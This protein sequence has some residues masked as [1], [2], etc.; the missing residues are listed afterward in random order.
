MLRAFSAIAAIIVSTSVRFAIAGKYLTTGQDA[1]KSIVT[2]DV[3]LQRIPAGHGAENQPAN[4]AEDEIQ[5]G[6]EAIEGGDEDGTING[7]LE[8]SGTRRG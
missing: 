1:Q 3:L 8:I 6:I 2:D 4:A 5:I 7:L